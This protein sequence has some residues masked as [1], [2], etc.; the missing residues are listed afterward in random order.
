MKITDKPNMP[1]MEGH[2]NRSSRNNSVSPEKSPYSGAVESESS[3]AKASDNV[4]LSAKAK[5]L[6]EARKVLDDTAEIRSEKVADIKSR[7]ASGSYN[8]KGEEIADAIIKA[9]LVD[10]TI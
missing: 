4:R 2:I 3:A 7:I 6:Q 5:E 8:V 9:S 1:E 10:K